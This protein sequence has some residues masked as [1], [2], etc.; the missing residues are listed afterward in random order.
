MLLRNLTLKDRGFIDKFLK[1]APRQLSVYAFE[2]IYI[3]KALFDIRWML[4]EGNLCVFFKDRIGTFLYLS[5]LGGTRS[6]KAIERVFEI[7]C[8]LNSNKEF[9]HIEN[10]Q[11][12][13]VEFFRRLGYR[14]EAKPGEYLYSRSK[15]AALKGNSFKS[16]RAGVNYF[17]KHY[18]SDYEPFSLKHKNQ[19]L[20]LFKLWMLER[21]AH[22][23]DAFY[24]GM[25]EDSF[26]VLGMVFKNY[27]KLNFSGGVVKID[28]EVK[29]FTLGFPLSGSIFCILYE[30]ADL[31]V[32][33]AAQF[34]FQRFCGE[35]KDYKYINVMDD[36]G[37]E[38]LRKVKLSYRPDKI[39]SSYIARRC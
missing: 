32:R 21:K 36:S 6:A 20:R 5:P 23:R 29:A 34:I 18:R 4:I 24:Q 7:L 10:I 27:S 33:G 17:I 37:L 19:C 16:R 35:L 1:A 25:L 2:N 11:D 12:S 31:S 13:D 26:N 22:C 39:I 38:N 28:G 30:A 9:A 15:L 14:C 8:R 3:W